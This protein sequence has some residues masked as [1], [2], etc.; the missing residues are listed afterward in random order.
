[1]TSLTGEYQ[2]T[3]DAK[4]RLFIPAKLREELGNVFFVTI[5]LDQCLSIYPVEGW[6]SFTARFNALPSAQARKARA[7][8]AS[9]AKC[10]LDAQGRILLPQKLRDYAQLDKDVTV[11]GV[12]SRAEIWNSDIYRAYEE[13]TLK[14]ENLAEIMETLGL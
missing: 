1:V 5:G 9:A 13:E 7:F 8:F 3:I 2:H 12:A 6:E 4:G 14:P 11:I 10:E